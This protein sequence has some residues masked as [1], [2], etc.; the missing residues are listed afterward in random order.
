MTFRDSD[1]HAAP[2]RSVGQRQAHR[3][4]ITDILAGLLPARPDRQSERV[5]KPFP[6]TFDVKERGETPTRNQGNLHDHNH[7]KSNC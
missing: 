3:H 2:C 6:N 5:K 4:A 7:E 1:D